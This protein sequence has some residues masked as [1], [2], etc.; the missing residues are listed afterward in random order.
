MEKGIGKDSAIAGHILPVG[1]YI[2]MIVQDQKS[3]AI[4]VVKKQ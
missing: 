4:K 1:S 3:L 2:L